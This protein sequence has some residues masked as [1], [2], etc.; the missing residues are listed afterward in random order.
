MAAAERER[1]G[2]R[3][4]DNLDED[5]I[6]EFLEFARK[7]TFGARVV[8][9]HAMHSEYLRAV[10]SYTMEQGELPL[11]LNYEMSPD[12]ELP[13]AI[14]SELSPTIDSQPQGPTEV[15]KKKKK[16]KKK[17]QTSAH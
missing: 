13:P 5:D 10:L 16:G 9:T 7:T 12:S 3:S 1:V 2:L 14:D 17:K 6:S 8:S 4:F 11:A 15:K